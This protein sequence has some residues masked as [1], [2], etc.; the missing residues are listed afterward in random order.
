MSSPP[1]NDDSPAPRRLPAL[2]VARGIA[3]VAMIGYHTCWDLTFF[4]LVRLD[5]FGSP[6]W[7]A[8]RTG[9]LSSFL[10]LSGF[11][12]ALATRDGIEW[13]RV[14]RRLA[15]LGGAAA[16]VTAASAWMFPDGLI[17]FGVLHHL[18][19]ASLFGLAFLRLPPPLIAALGLL[20]LGLPEQFSHPFFDQ[21][22]LRWIGLIT[23]EP[24]TND[25]VP[26]F[27]WFGVVL[28]GIALGRT[29]LTRTL[30][31]LPALPAAAARAGAPLAWLGRRSLAVYLLHQPLLFAVLFALTM[32]T[33]LGVPGGTL[34]PDLPV[35]PGLPDKAAG[36]LGSCQVSCEKSG[37]SLSRCAGYCRCMATELNG[38]GLWDDFLANKLNQAGQTQLMALIQSCAARPGS[39]PA[40][41]PGQH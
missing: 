30:P 6:F 35:A 5:L 31:P 10:L 36:F 7:L 18:T 27:P 37:G 39:A 41:Q 2:D 15:L 20:A 4:G 34:A 13:R 38:R 9:I 16:A 25:F 11:S 19:L 14:G 23:Q 40:G 21:H 8:V 32:A 24:R 29:A 26:L 28:M 12:L 33:G 1:A 22:G 17:F 3:I